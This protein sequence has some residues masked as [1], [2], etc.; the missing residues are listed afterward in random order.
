M[1]FIVF[2]IKKFFNISLIILIFLYVITSIQGIPIA[3]FVLGTWQIKRWL[4]K[5]D[6]IKTLKHR[7][8]AEPMDL[9]SEYIMMIYN[10]YTAVYYRHFIEICSFQFGSVKG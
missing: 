8:S 4:W 10:V 5:L 2:L 1:Q 6:L 3:T 9:P 7:T